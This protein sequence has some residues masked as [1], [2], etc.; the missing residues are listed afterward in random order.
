MTIQTTDDRELSMKMGDEILS[1]L[2]G[3]S[4]VLELD[5][6]TLAEHLLSINNVALTYEKD[7][8]LVTTVC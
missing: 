2:L 8:F 7:T 5:E 6:D 4:D 3:K 1:K